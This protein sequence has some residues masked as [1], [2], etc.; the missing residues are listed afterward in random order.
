M[1]SDQE[2]CDKKMSKFYV[3]QLYSPTDG[4]PQTPTNVS[5]GEPTK[6]R[7]FRLLLCQ[8]NGLLQA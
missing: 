3:P 4:G 1:T 5:H 6:Q 7:H 2:L 8:K